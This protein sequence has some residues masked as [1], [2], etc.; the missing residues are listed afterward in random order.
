[1]LDLIEPTTHYETGANYP[2]GNLLP[3][4]VRARK[5]LSTMG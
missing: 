3:H 4:P 1:M 5:P 2:E